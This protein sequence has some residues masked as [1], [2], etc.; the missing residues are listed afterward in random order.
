MTMTERPVAL[1]SDPEGV[2][3]TEAVSLLQDAGFD[4][5]VEDLRTEAELMERVADAQPVALLVTYLPV[6]EAV[7]SAGASLRIVS[8]SSVGFDHVDLAAAERHGVWVS[9]VPDAASEEVAGHALAMALAL[10]RHLPFLDRHVREGGWQYDATG[11]PRRLSELTLG[12]VGMGRIGRRLAGLAS[13]VFGQVVGCDPFADDGG[14]PAAVP[15]LGLDRCLRES[16]VISLHLPLSPQTRGLID[17]D[18]LAGMT[19][20]AMLVNVSRGGLV[21]EEA[22]L[23]ALDSGHLAAAGLDVTDPEPPPAESL[24]RRH[25]R[26][27]L[28]PH[29]AWLSEQ[30]NDAYVMRQAGN[31]VAWRRDGRPGTPV[32]HPPEAYPTNQE[33]QTR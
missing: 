28:T 30:A 33:V 7:R 19:P 9:N 32:N 26:V 23:A 18:A 20:G 24:L 10:V 11:V 21:D 13:G 17:A 27:L 14:W 12:V 15:R 16:E 29:A 8:C 22:L 6:T 5:L 3:L 31:V 25:P 4:V 2:E 1:Y